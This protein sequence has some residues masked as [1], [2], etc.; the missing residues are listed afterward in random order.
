MRLSAIL[1]VT[2]L[3]VSL[4]AFAQGPP[5][6]EVFGGYRFA[7]LDSTFSVN[8]K[9]PALNG[10]AASITAILSKHLGVTADFGG[11][12]W[13]QE[14]DITIQSAQGSAP[15][16]LNLDHRTYSYLFGPSLAFPSRRRITPYLHAQF[17]V[18]RT[19]TDVLVRAGNTR[20]TSHQ[21]ETDFTMVTGAGMDVRMTR[22]VLVRVGE[23]DYL[24]LRHQSINTRNFAM[25]SGLVFIY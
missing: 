18:S 14:R 4:S 17:G 6:V 16:H 21:T 13:S 2:C 19:G 1:L 12:Y 11:F 3:A 22:H 15:A 7:S 8:K 10:W 5:K 25:R 23:L 20:N 24:L 9:R